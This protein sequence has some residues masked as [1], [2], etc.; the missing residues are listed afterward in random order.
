MSKPQKEIP[1]FVQVLKRHLPPKELESE[2]ISKYNSGGV[3][4]DKEMKKRNPNAQKKMMFISSSTPIQTN[5]SK[6]RIKGDE[7]QGYWVYCGKLWYV[8]KIEKKFE[9][10]QY[11]MYNT[12]TK[13]TEGLWDEETC[14]ES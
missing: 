10:A 11:L 6:Y 13:L 2:L 1:H 3:E 14:R 5:N 7:E 9:F 8:R 4:I 12:K